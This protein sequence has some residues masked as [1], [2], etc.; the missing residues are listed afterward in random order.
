M[1]EKLT[2]EKIRDAVKLLREGEEL[3][4]IDTNK[5]RRQFI[6]FYK[7][8]AVVSNR[9]QDAATNYSEED[10]QNND[11]QILK[12]EKKKKK[13]YPA[14]LRYLKDGYEVSE[15][16]FDAEQFKECQNSN[17]KFVRLLT[18][19]PAIEVTEDE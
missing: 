8:M 10:I 16:L 15:A 14:L 3:W 19:Y 2:F 4:F 13:L 17:N 18:E 9:H 5:D 6:S 12:P 1:T 7:D 11:W